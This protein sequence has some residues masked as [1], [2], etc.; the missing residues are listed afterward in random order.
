MIPLIIGNFLFGGLS[1]YLLSKVF[2]QRE[3]IK[4][5]AELLSAIEKIKEKNSHFNNQYEKELLN[6]GLNKLNYIELPEE[7]NNAK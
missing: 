2:S 5:Q 1:I 3:K 6:I 4:R 7:N